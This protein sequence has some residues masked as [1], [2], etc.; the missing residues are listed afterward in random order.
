[1]QYKCSYITLSKNFEARIHPSLFHYYWKRAEDKN[2]VLPLDYLT[3]SMH[4]SSN[5]CENV[6]S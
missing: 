3:T 4:V 5:K 6:T 1:M 2:I